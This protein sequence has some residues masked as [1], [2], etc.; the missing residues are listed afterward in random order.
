MYSKGCLN[1]K[2]FG[3]SLYWSSFIIPTKLLKRLLRRYTTIF[4]C[5]SSPMKKYLLWYVSTL[6]NHL[7]F[8]KE[9][10]GYRVSRVVSLTTHIV[11]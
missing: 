7:E 11:I 6:F 1:L 3:R 9:N 4:V 8:I 2:M 10:N 5:T